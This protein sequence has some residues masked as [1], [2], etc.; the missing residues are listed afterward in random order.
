M[1]HIFFIH[2]SVDGHLSCFHIL[3]IRNRAA[4]DIGYMYCFE[5]QFSQCICLGVWLLDHMVALF[6]IFLRSLHIVFHSHCTNLY[7]H[8][9]CRRV[10]FSLHPLQHLLFLHFLMMA[11]LTD[12]SSK[13]LIV[14]LICLSLIFSNAGHFLICLLAICMSSLKKSLFRSST[15]WLG[16]LF[17]DIE[18][19]VLF[20]YFRD[21]SLV[22]SF[23]CKYFLPF[24]GWSFCFV[25][26]SFAVK[27]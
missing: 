20:V 6:L 9:Q 21:Q 3:A 10:T 2:S 18:P 14:I 23:M 15:F 7:S 24:H 8:Q 17:F 26:G 22:S 5:L 19:H 11:I 16:C 27:I 4:M 13:W 1:Y 25:H 12:V